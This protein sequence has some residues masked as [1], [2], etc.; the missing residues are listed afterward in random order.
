M[1]W[2]VGGFNEDYWGYGCEDCDFYARLSQ[3]ARWTEQRSFDLLHLWHDRVDGWDKHHKEN[4]NLERILSGNDIQ[5][6]VRMQYA[7]LKR[8]GYGEELAKFNIE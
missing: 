2:R 5:T 6:R 1:Y 3:A 4:K 7:Q 8:L